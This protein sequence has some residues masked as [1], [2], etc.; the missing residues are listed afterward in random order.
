MFPKVKKNTYAFMVCILLSTILVL[1]GCPLVVVAI[2][3]AYRDEG[4]IVTVEVPKSAP[5][6][7]AAGKKRLERGVSETGIPYKVISIDED[8][9]TVSIEGTDGTWRGEFIVVPISAKVS[10]LIGQGTDD[11]RAKDESEDLILLGIKNVCDDLG[12][13]Y[14]VITKHYDVDEG[15]Q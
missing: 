10:Q 9:Y 8:N 15:A 7:F 4:V 1:Q 5:E 14:T 3:A 6:V 12:V 13:E 11:M 2:V